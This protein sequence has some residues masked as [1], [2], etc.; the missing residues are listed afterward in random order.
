MLTTSLDGIALTWAV[1]M[2]EGFVVEI[3][4][5]PWMG[6]P[7]TKLK[8]I[9]PSY[10]HGHFPDFCTKSE[11]CCPIMFREKIQTT[12]LLGPKEEWRA[13]MLKY[14]F[15]QALGP[16]PF[17]AAMRCWVLSQVGEHITLPPELSAFDKGDSYKNIP[18]A[19]F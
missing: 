3:K 14:G 2:L 13:T 15:T 8:I 17:I 16:T 19:E 11:E 9:S 10:W 1:S 5:L 7:T 18:G 4:T 6:V 12:P